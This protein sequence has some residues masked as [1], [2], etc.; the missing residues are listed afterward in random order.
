MQITDTCYIDAAP[1][2]VWAVT[3]DVERWPDWTPTVTAV[4]RLSDGPF[5]LGA[6]ARLKQ[7]AQPEAVWTVVEYVRGERFAW[8][9][10]T[11]GLRLLGAHELT[12]RGGGTLNRLRVEVDGPMAPFLGPLLR[13]LLRRALADENRG[14]KAHCEARGGARPD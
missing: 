13:P 5:G 12:P 9:A 3:E 10:R 4:T 1:D 2:L 11:L 14:L 8:A 7:P 6:Q